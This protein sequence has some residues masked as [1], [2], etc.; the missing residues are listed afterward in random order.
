M[1][2]GLAKLALAG[3]VLFILN[4]L[5]MI[6]MYLMALFE[7]IVVYLCVELQK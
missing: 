3:F 2:A 1:H 5:F 4:L 7:Q 6:I